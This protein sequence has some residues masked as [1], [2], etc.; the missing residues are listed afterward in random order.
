MSPRLEGHAAHES[1]IHFETLIHF[2]RR[3]ALLTR[4][5]G[6]HSQPVDATLAIADIAKATSFWTLARQARNRG[7]QQWMN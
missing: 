7:T 1:L 3:I 2:A 5:G 6:R 4:H